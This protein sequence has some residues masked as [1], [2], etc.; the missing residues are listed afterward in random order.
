MSYCRE[1]QQTLN[2]ED[3]NDFSQAFDTGECIGR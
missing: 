3:N 2:R 1:A